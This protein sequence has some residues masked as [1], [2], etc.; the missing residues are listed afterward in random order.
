MSIQEEGSAVGTSQSFEATFASYIAGNSALWVLN[1]SIPSLD[2]VRGKIV[3]LRR[4][5]ALAS[6]LGID[7]SRWPDNSTF[8]FEKIKVQDI[9]QVQDHEAKWKAFTALLDDAKNH[10]P[11]FLCIN[12]ASGVSSTFGIPNINSVSD[13]INAWITNYIIAN[14]RSITGIIVMDFADAA[15]C[16]LIY[17]ANSMP[18]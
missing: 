12:F 11:E 18:K 16:K 14:T 15:K 13:D 3:L 2:Q 5:R 4:F 10:S 8:T 6:P 9:Y 1:D 7:A 17:D